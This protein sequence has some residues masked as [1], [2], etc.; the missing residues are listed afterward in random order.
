MKGSR[1]QKEKGGGKSC[2]FGNDRREELFGE[3]SDRSH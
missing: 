2:W 3:V 1:F